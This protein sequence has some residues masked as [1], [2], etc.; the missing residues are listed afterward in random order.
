ME[1]DVSVEN[2]CNCYLKSGFS[3]RYEFK[4]KDEAKKDADYILGIMKSNFCQKHKFLIT[5]K[6]NG[7]VISM[8]D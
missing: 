6:E 3:Q 4:T 5:E 2:P 7:F 8:Q 1:F